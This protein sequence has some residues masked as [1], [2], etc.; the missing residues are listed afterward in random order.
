MVDL[1]IGW[2]TTLFHSCLKN[3]K[4]KNYAQPCSES[5]FIRRKGKLL[6]FVYKNAIIFLQDKFAP[7]LALLIKGF[8]FAHFYIFCSPSLFFVKVCFLVLFRHS[9]NTRPRFHPTAVGL[10]LQ[11]RVR[12]PCDCKVVTVETPCMASLLKAIAFLLPAS[13]RLPHL[14]AFSPSP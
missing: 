14:R 3:L 10:R 1:P 12:K 5:F 4:I 9:G 6:H 13:H 8:F 11:V 7:H 2:S